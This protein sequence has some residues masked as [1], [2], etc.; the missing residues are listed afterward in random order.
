M[1]TRATS[2]IALR[3]PPI[4]LDIQALAGWSVAIAACVGLSAALAS[5]GRR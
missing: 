5:A 3:T 2:T 1:S 4:A